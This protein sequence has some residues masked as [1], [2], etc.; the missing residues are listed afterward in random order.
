MQN[1]W[2]FNESFASNS[3]IFE[4]KNG[5]EYFKA[6][7][8]IN[9]H[10]F[11]SILFRVDFRSTVLF[12]YWPVT[13]IG[14]LPFKIRFSSEVNSEQLPVSWLGPRR[15]RLLN[16]GYQIGENEFKSA[17]F[18]LWYWCFTIKTG[19]NSSVVVTITTTDLRYH[20]I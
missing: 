15:M 5:I 4:Y 19:F 8:F 20:S 14:Y 9:E 2:Y 12:L 11:T 3:D 18:A 1:F 10:P 16:L 7:I 13:T 6:K 17:T